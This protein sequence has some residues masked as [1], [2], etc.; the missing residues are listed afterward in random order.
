VVCCCSIK[1]ICQRYDRGI[2]RRKM[3]RG[4]PRTFFVVAQL[5]EEKRRGREKM[6]A[7]FS[8]PFLLYPHFRLSLSLPLFSPSPGSSLRQRESF[9]YLEEKCIPEEKG[10]GGKEEDY[11]DTCAV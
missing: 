5:P 4:Q 2:K 1:A 7:T 11:K 6:P 8:L 10:G 9:V 3:R